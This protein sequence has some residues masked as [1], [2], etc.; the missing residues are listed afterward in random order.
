[1]SNLIFLGGLDSTPYTDDKPSLSRTFSTG[2]RVYSTDGIAQTISSQGG[3]PGSSSGLYLVRES[4]DR[5]ESN[6]RDG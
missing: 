6:R 3:G 4:D 5:G 1:M 2:Y